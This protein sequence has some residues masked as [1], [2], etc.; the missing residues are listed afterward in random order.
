MIDLEG[1]LEA[2]NGLGAV[3]EDASGVVH[4]HVDARAGGVQAGRERADVVEP[5]E[6]GQEVVGGEFAATAWVLS[7]ER[8]TMTTRWPSLCS[9]GA[10]G[11]D[12]V[13]GAGDDDGLDLMSS[14]Q[15]DDT[16]C[17]SVTK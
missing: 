10:G 17:P 14:Y 13:A 8:P 12:S 3:A 15:L 7:G 6:V 2:V 1:L 16:I 9:S 5:G 4:E 11:A